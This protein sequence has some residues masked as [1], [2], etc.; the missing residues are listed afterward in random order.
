MRKRIRMAGFVLMAVLFLTACRNPGK[1]KN[2]QEDKPEEA[3]LQ[4][5]LAASLNTAMAEL[6]ELWQEQH[7]EVKIVCNAAGSGCLAAQIEE[8]CECDVFF[9]A[10]GKQM[11][12]LEEKGLIVAGTRENVVKNQVVVITRTGS[13]TKV[14]GLENLEAAVSIALA[15]G[16]VPV[17]RYTRQALINLNR[18]EGADDPSLITTEQV[19][20]A[21]GGVE[22]SEQDNVSKVLLAVAEGS[23]E[24]GTVYYSDI[25]GYEDKVEILQIVEESLTGEVSYP[26]AQVVNPE[27][28]EAQ[29]AAARDFISFLLSDTARSI[30]EKY[31][32]IL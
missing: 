2:P 7:P 28:G 30:F 24:V 8:G 6:S 20:E 26:V 17:G 15:G 12:Q 4:V 19:S 11:N 29:T 16:S 21:L 13:G 32:F 10:A 27:A 3:E 22:I 5:F 31:Y 23:C 9:S 1:Q 25:Y 14:K 18:L